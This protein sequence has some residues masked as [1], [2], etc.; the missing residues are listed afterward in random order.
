MDKKHQNQNQE[1][2]KFRV[3]W[4][5][6]KLVWARK[7]PIVYFN[8]YLLYIVRFRVLAYPKGTGILQNISK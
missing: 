7:N 2:G 8:F 1:W 5:F 6:D 4:S 3:L